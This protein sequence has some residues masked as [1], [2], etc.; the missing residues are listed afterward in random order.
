MG[1]EAAKATAR[2]GQHD[3]PSRDVAWV[4]PRRRNLDLCRLD[5]CRL[6]LCRLDLCCLGCVAHGVPQKVRIPIRPQD[7]VPTGT[8]TAHGRQR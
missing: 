1:K 5:L 8:I 3:P 6:D 7:L 4:G 2:T